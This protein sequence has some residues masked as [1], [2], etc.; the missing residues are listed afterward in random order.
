MSHSSAPNMPRTLKY[1]SIYGIRIYAWHTH[2]C[3]WPNIFRVDLLPFDSHRCPRVPPKR[4]PSHNPPHIKLYT[5]S[6]E[7]AKNCWCYQTGREPCSSDPEKR[8]VLGSAALLKK[9]QPWPS[10]QRLMAADV[11]VRRMTRTADCCVFPFSSLLIM[12][13]VEPLLHKC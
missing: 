5:D 1:I 11:M 2:L 7:A 4:Q 8:P 9:V 10:P 13:A 3:L 6:D 12:G